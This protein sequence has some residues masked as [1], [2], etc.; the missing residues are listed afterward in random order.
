MAIKPLHD[1]VLLKAIVEEK[2]SAS[3]IILAHEESVAPEK[4]TVVSVGT[5][6]YMPNGN[7]VA[8]AVIPGDVVLFK[9]YS[10]EAVSVDGEDLLM[11]RETDIRAVVTKKE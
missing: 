11:L 6:R 7:L 8:P 1:F 5:G 4:G 10:A 9:A 3:G 2:K